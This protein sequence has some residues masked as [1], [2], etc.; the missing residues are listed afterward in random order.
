MLVGDISPNPWD[1]CRWQWLRVPLERWKRKADNLIDEIFLCCAA[2]VVGKKFL[3]N[4]PHWPEHCEVLSYHFWPAYRQNRLSV[5][6]PEDRC[7]PPG[8]IWQRGAFWFPARQNDS[9]P[10][11]AAEFQLHVLFGIFCCTRLCD[12]LH[13]QPANFCYSVSCCGQ[14]GTVSSEVSITISS[15]GFKSSVKSC[16]RPDRKSVV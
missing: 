10:P 12:I 11:G 5:F 7:I 14:S 4:I 2:V 16:C 13:R 3:I 8:E 6:V 9:L 15:A 1:H